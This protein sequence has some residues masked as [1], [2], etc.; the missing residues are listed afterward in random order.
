MNDFVLLALIGLLFF[1]GCINQDSKTQLMTEARFV[2]EINNGTFESA[3]KLVPLLSSCYIIKNGI[4]EK[5]YEFDYI[6][7]KVVLIEVKK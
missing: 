4:I 3:N 1:S 7:K 2:C 6:N 5:K